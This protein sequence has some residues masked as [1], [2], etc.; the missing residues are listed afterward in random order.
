MEQ[1]RAAF[2]DV[3]GFREGLSLVAQTLITKRTAA[4]YGVAFRDGPDTS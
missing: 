4:R 1:L 3:L 2:R